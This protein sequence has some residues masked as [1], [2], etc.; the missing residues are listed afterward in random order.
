MC[1]Y[2]V[3]WHDDTNVVKEHADVDNTYTED[4]IMMMLEFSIDISS[5]GVEGLFLY[6]SVAFSQWEKWRR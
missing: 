3:V 4:D 2:L 1:K 6:E 5:L